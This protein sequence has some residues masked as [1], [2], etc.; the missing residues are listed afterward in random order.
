MTSDVIKNRPIKSLCVK[1]H[2]SVPFAI[3][4]S[5]Q[6]ARRPLSS[7]RFVES[8]RKFLRVQRMLYIGKNENKF[9]TICSWYFEFLRGKEISGDSNNRH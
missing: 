8:P 6:Q 4:N 1:S 7:N 2:N 9:A 3:M 5:R